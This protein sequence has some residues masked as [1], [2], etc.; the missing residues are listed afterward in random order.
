[1]KDELRIGLQSLPTGI[2]CMGKMSLEQLFSSLDWVT[3]QNS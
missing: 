1:V 2:T 3:L